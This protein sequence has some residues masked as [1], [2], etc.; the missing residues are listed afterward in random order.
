MDRSK[1]KRTAL[2]VG[3]IAAGFYSGFYVLILV[4]K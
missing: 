2:L 1:A 3:L 4:M